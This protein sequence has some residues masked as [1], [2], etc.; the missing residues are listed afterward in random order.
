M[1]AV[2]VLSLKRFQRPVGPARIDF[3]GC[4]CEQ[5][6]RRAVARHLPSQAA[7]EWDAMRFRSF[8]CAAFFGFNRAGR[9]RECPERAVAGEC[10]GFG[11]RDHWNDG[12]DE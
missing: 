2:F 1:R 10:Y 3:S 11:R 6:N 12:C 7:D 8:E 5:S 9:G 4:S